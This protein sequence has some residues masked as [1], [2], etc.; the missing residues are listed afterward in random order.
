MCSQVHP[1]HFY[2]WGSDEFDGVMNNNLNADRFINF[3]FGK[4]TSSIQFM[5]SLHLMIT[6]CGALHWAKIWKKQ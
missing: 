5:R 3:C 2:E 1:T 4:A 6:L